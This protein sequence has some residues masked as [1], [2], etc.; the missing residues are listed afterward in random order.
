MTEPT[1]DIDK[2][3]AELTLEEKAR[4]TAGEDLWST[5][6][7]DRLGIPKVRMND[8]PNGAR[9]SALLGAGPTTAACT[10]C[11]SALGATW[12]PALVER[13][14]AMV[15]EEARPKACRVL[16]G[17]TVNIHR[18]PLG[19]RN[20]ECYA[21][22]PLLA[23]RIAAAFVRGVQS[24]GVI[25]TVKHFAGNDAGFERN[26]HLAVIGPNADRA[27][28]IGGGSASLR[29][30]YQIT[31]LQAIRTH[32]SDRVAIRH[33]RGCDTDRTTPPLGGTQ[34]TTPDGRPGLAVELFADPDLAGPAVHRCVS[35]DGRLL[36]FGAPAPKVPAGTFSLRA[37]GRF[38]PAGAGPHTFTLVQTGRAP[39][40]STARSSSTARPIPRRRA[41]RRFMSVARIVHPAL[42]RPCKTRRLQPD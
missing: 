32:L 15:G 13:V 31:P 20:F 16:L 25:T 12:N 19:G 28:I 33:E 29:P 36:F 4:L 34:I 41:R 9:G 1:R 8:G 27:Q 23:G 42:F 18:S 14:G 37:T 40:W 21:E 7:I 11:G 6:A 35:P 5:V 39:S 26:A 22:D 17:P 10:P 30:H 3:V 38:T 24:R 2:L